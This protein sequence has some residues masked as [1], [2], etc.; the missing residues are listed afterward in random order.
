MESSQTTSPLNVTHAPRVKGQFDGLLK[1][2]VRTRKTSS[3]KLPLHLIHISQHFVERVQFHISHNGKQY[4]T[5][6]DNCNLFFAFLFIF[7]TRNLA[8][9][10]LGRRGPRDD[11]ITMFLS[12]V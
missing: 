8:R 10:L 9:H 2:I 12:F 6:S 4:I 5:L 1:T 11:K 3:A 7:F